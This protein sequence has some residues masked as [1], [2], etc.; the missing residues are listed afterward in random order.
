[1]TLEKWQCHVGI[2]DS[3]ILENKLCQGGMQ[4]TATLDN[5]RVP[6]NNMEYLY[7]LEL[8]V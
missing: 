7:I 6:W 3:K 4:V 8:T 5:L 1:M 2:Q